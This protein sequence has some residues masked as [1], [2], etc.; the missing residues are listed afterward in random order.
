MAGEEFLGGRISEDAAVLAKNCSGNDLV[1][2]TYIIHRVEKKNV[3][4]FTGGC[5]YN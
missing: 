5:E 3:V 2:H 4:D 1:E